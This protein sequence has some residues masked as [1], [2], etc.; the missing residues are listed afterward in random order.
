[1]EKLLLCLLHGV[2][3]F[4]FLL[5]LPRHDLPGGPTELRIFFKIRICFWD[6]AENIK[7]YN[8][9]LMKRSQFAYIIYRMKRMFGSVKGQQYFLLRLIFHYKPS[10]SAAWESCC[11]LFRQFNGKNPTD[12]NYDAPWY[13]QNNRS[14]NYSRNKDGGGSIL[15]YC[16][17]L[18]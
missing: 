13:L 3:N 12:V 4:F 2:L 1:M 6:A 8:F 15:T 14:N 5:H 17:N 16:N 9:H 18:N 11:I 10:F 7:K